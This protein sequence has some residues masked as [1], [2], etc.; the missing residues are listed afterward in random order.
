MKLIDDMRREVK[1]FEFV[2]AS[3]GFLGLLLTLPFVLIGGGP[4]DGWWIGTLL[5]VVSWIAQIALMKF[6]V[7]LDGPQAVGIS[8]LSFM[9][10]AWI[11][12]GVLFVVAKRYDETAGLVAAG[13]FLAAFTFDLVGRMM[14]HALRMKTAQTE[15]HP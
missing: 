4:F 5:W 1:P 7:N 11:V 14:L 10:R 8:G 13:V 2:C 12:F 6:A 15:V 9:A 3:F